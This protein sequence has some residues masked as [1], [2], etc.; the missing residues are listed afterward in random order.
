MQIFKM[1]GYCQYLSVV[2]IDNDYI[3]NNMTH[4]LQF[5]VNLDNLSWENSSTDKSLQ[6]F[7]F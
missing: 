3:F 1:K 5:I 4:I 2:W 7:R 6:I